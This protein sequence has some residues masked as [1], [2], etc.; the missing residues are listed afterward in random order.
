MYVFVT[1]AARVITNLLMWYIHLYNLNCSTVIFELSGW[2]LSTNNHDKQFVWTQ[3]VRKC[4]CDI[5]LE[6]LFYNSSFPA[7]PAPLLLLFIKSHCFIASSSILCHQMSL[8]LSPSSVSLHFVP[9]VSHTLLPL[10]SYFPSSLERSVLA[11]LRIWAF[12]VWGTRDGCS[13]HTKETGDNNKIIIRRNY[14]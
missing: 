7:L 6:I 2:H 13:S 10:Y 3:E 9:L 11:S 14:S 8:P 5:R 12:I 4:Y 1:V